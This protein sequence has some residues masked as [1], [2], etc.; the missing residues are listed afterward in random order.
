M[1]SYF[2]RIAQSHFFRNVLVLMTGTVLAQAINVAFVPVLSRLYDPATYGVFGVYL[3]IVSIVSCVAS[4]RYDMAL[5]LPKDDRDAAGLLWLC[6]IVTSGIAAISMV[7]CV[8]FGGQIGRLLQTPELTPWLWAAPIS[9]FLIGIWQSLIFWATR[10]KKFHI[11]SVS[12][13]TRAAMGSGSQA[14][15]GLFGPSVLGLI[16]GMILGDACGSAVFSSQVLKRDWPLIRGALS[17]SRLKRLLREYSDFP[18]YTAPQSL[19][20]TVSAYVPSLLLAHYFGVAVV[21]YYT[22]GV[23]IVLLPAN[24]VGN[25]LRSVLF[26][27]A[28]EVYHSGGDTYALFKKATLGL[29]GMAALPTLVI[30]LLAPMLAAFIL[31]EEWRT[32][33]VYASWL[34]LWLA[35]GFCNVPAVLFGQIYRR[36]RMLFGVEVVLL[37]ARVLAIVLGGIYGTALQAVI[38]YSIVGVLYNAFLIAWAW[39]FL[40]RH[41][42][43]LSTTADFPADPSAAVPF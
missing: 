10:R 2:S 41:H 19:L 39:T 27:K 14:A 4:L 11:T 36:Q 9:I 12:Q 5:M 43:T 33:G 22:F 32:A 21:G 17:R 6:G 35:V 18:V 38:L 37:V 13:V 29:M 24:L 8:C 7:V 26:Q 40:R 16:F 28:T 15:A 30:M 25:S 42:L 20:N 31:G 3:S 34:V 23:R 1:L